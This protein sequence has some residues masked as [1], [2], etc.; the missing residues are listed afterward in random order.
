MPKSSVGSNRRTRK[1]VSVLDSRSKADPDAE[2][3]A[4]ALNCV[5]AL[6]LGLT[7]GPMP[8]E[9]TRNSE[10]ER[11]SPGFRNTLRFDSWFRVR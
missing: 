2:L 6:D 5:A 9:K 1:T 8:P 7:F 11:R 10:S 4:H 3:W